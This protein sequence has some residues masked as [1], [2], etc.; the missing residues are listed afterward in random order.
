M[1]LVSEYRAKYSELFDGLG[2]LLDNPYTIKL[3]DGASPFA[4]T[5]LRRVPYSMLPKVKT[6]LVA[7]GVI[8]M[9]VWSS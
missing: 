7:Q 3:K 8:S 2:E 1:D 9:T 6:E 4:L 5:V